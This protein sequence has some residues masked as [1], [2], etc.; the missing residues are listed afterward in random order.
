MPSIDRTPFP[1]ARCAARICP[2]DRAAA[3]ASPPIDRRDIGA[4]TAAIG[5]GDRHRRSPRPPPPSPT[6]PTQ[7]DIDRLSGVVAADPDDAEAQ[8]DLGFAL[9]QRVRETADPSLYEPAVDGVRR[10]RDGWPPT[11]PWS[12]SASAGSSS[13]S[14]SSPR[15]SRPAGRPPRSRRASP[16]PGRSSSM[17][18]SSSADTTKPTQSRGGDVRAQRRPLDAARV[19]RTSPNCAGTSTWHLSAMRLAARHARAR[20]PRTPPSCRRSSGT[21]SSTRATRRRPPRPTDAP[22]SSCRPMRRRWPARL[23]W[24]SGRRP[25]RRRSRSSQRASRDRAVARIRHRAGR[26]PGGRRPGR[27]A[28]EQSFALARAEIQLFEASGV[29]VDLDLA[30]FEADHGD[31]A[32]RS[33][34]P[35]RPT[36]PRP[37]SAPPTP[38]PGRSTASAATTKRRPYVDEALRLGSRDPLLRYHAGAIAAAL[39]DAAGA[40]RD[41]ELALATDPGFSATGA[42]EARRILADCPTE[43]RSERPIHPT[44]R[45]R[46]HQ[47]RQ[48]LGVGRDTLGWTSP[49]RGLGEGRGVPP[50]QSPGENLMS[51]RSKAAAILGA[52]VI[53]TTS[54]TGVFASSHREAPLI[55]GDPNADNTD[56][57]AFVS[58]DDPNSLTIIANYIPLEE[59]AGGPNF[60]PFDDDRPL[61]DPHRQQRRRQARHPLRLP[62]QDPTEGQ[63]LRRASRRSSTTTGRS[64][65]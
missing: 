27:A 30:L 4:S 46:A 8:R 52:V 26:H 64:R 12:W 10:R 48:R 3:G 43:S 2:G 11:T 61:R 58:P 31:P 36:R 7:A 54:I 16:R 37:P 25:R 32:G 24:R 42:A 44:G 19:S 35:R 15:R 45:G 62:V 56:L 63:Q 20:A 38:S 21:C 47:R 34:S 13:A 55:S 28:A 23:G 49:P 22:S 50:P 18:W 57:Y 51:T 53:A 39:G 65:A 5:G 6:S 59:P 1:P 9:L 60:F 40:R 14:T 29:I 33:S 41:L 17:P